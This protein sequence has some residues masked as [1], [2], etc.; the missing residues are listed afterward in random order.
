MAVLRV[1]LQ[2][3]GVSPA[4]FLSKNSGTSSNIRRSR[5]MTLHLLQRELPRKLALRVA[6][7]FSTVSKRSW[8]ALKPLSSEDALEAERILESTLSSWSEEQFEEC[9]KLGWLG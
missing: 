2:T 5:Q 4:V 8:G 9:V 3:T 6:T 7:G 1:V